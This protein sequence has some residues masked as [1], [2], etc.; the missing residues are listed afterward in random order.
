[1]VPSSIGDVTDHRPT[2]ISAATVICSM[3]G[4]AV[5]GGNR[6]QREP[7]HAAVRNVPGVGR[8]GGLKKLADLDENALVALVKETARMGFVYTCPQSPVCGEA[9]RSSRGP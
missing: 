7:R 6:P 9:V 8:S 2:S 1:M 3:G 4:P 5:G